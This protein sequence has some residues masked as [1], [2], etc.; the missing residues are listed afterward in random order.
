VSGAEQELRCEH[1]VDVAAYVLGSLPDHETAPLLA[2]LQECAVCGAELAQLQAVADS[3]A[4]GVVR[5]V[6]PQSL[7][8]RIM[9]TVNAEA[10]LLEAAGH[11]ADRPV[12]AR[13]R[14]QWRLAPALAATAALGVGLLIG[15]L[16]INPGSGSQ[17]VRTQVI[18]AI[19]V[20]PGHN[21][22]AELRKAGSHLQLVVLGLPAPPR[23]RIYEVWLE[24]GTQAPEPTNAL[25]SVTRRGNGEVGVPGNPS[26]VSKVLVTDEPL[27]GSDKPTRNPIIVAST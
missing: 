8:A 18:R 5:K 15:A 1:C 20:A 11:E 10:E 12:R 27:G 24:R 23:G 16:A 19:V 26:G 2:H 17:R 13:P 6:A 21:A 22:R 4:L 7:R 3:L 14:W 25:F 9:A